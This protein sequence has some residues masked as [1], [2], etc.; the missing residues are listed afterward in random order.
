[1]NRILNLT[2]HMATPSQV[3]EGVF[4]PADKKEV[5]NLL[6]FATLPSDEQV[7][8]A[9]KRLADVAAREMNPP[10]EVMIGGAPYLMPALQSALAARGLQAIYS[11]SE[12]KC[13]EEALPDGTVKKTMIFDRTGFVR[14]Y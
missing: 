7:W 3:E 12:R 2:Q 11:F 10:G 4:E 6:T 8:T 5:Q 13:I 14:T 9:A 1:M